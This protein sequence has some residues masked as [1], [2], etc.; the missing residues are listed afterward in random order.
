MTILSVPDMHCDHCVAR[1]TRAL[2][3]EGV[4]FQV[5]LADKTVSVEGDAAMV[6]RV[7][8]ALND[9]G[10]EAQPR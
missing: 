2:T 5:S 4:P 3:K 9:L 10:F 6:T 7:V 8:E 1:I